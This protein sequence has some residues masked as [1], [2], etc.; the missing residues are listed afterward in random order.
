MS[1]KVKNKAD[2]KA[3][4]FIYGDIVDNTDFKWDE[5][6]VMPQD[7]K[8]I[9]EELEGVTNLD[10]FINSGGGSVF[11]GMA[12]FHMLKRHKAYKTVHVDGIAAS[13]ASVI[14]LAGDKVII[15]SNAYFMIHK[16]W[17]GMMGNADEF[18][19]VADTLDKVD[20]GILN[21]YT[22]NLK[23]GVDIETIKQ[24][25]VAETWMTGD[26][27]AQ[28][29]NIETSSAVAIAASTSDYYA[30]YNKIPEEL[31][32]KANKEPKKQPI[33]PQFTDIEKQQYQNELDML[34]L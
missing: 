26:E 20:E 31:V 11:S 1:L 17:S 6:D 24:M 16:A 14:A 32:V 12:I 15:P 2:N 34:L 28:Y 21:T 30:K 25:V 19:K 4:L 18:R 29:F 3:E 7:V 22:D 13:I 27:A 5:F 10:I 8:N 23:E 9:L 33:I